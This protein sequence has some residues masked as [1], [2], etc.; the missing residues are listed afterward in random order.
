MKL[1]ETNVPVSKKIGHVK[2]LLLGRREETGIATWSALV[3]A[4]G[5]PTLALGVGRL[6]S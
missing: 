5:Q 2:D 1:N 3:L 6:G 4:R